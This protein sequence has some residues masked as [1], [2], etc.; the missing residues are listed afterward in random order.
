MSPFLGGLYVAGVL[1]SLLLRFCNSRW[2]PTSIFLSFMV[3]M[4][5]ASLQQDTGFEEYFISGEQIL[6]IIYSPLLAGSIDLADVLI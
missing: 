3:K 6:N 1:C 4:T 5:Q 2:L